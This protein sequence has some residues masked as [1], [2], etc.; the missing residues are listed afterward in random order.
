MMPSRHS[1]RTR[2]PAATALTQRLRSPRFTQPKAC[3][4]KRTRPKRSQSISRFS[5]KKI[6]LRFVDKVE[7]I[8]SH[9]TQNG[10]D[11]N[12]VDAPQETLKPWLGVFWGGLACGVHD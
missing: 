6:R 1:Q 5:N 12:S 7:V 8:A 2:N 11:M 3:S 9:A 4:A 10:A